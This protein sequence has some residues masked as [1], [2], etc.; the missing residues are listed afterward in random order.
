MTSEEIR[1]DEEKVLVLKSEC[2]SEASNYEI[3]ELTDEDLWS[4]SH[5]LVCDEEVTHSEESDDI[6]RK[7][8]KAL[9][10]IDVIDR[11]VIRG[12]VMIFAWNGK[13]VVGNSIGRF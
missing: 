7:V 4:L 10:N 13:T 9:V 6:C 3:V 8:Y 11:V 12:V 2:V 1:L 5:N